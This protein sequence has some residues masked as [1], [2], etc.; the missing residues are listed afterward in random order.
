MRKLWL[1]PL[2]LALAL[3]LSPAY[4]QAPD[5]EAYTVQA[6]DWLSKLAE[7][8][9]GDPLAY[10]AIVDATNAKAAED[11]RFTAITNPDAIE[12]GQK[13]WI[14][15]ST[16]TTA[17]PGSGGGRLSVDQLKNASYDGIY[18]QPVTLVDGYYEGEP[19]VEG[20]A[21]RPTVTFVGDLVAYGDLNGDGVEDAAVLLAESSGGSGTFTYLAAVVNQDGQPVNA[22][23]VLLGDRTQIKSL[24]IQNGQIVMEIVTQGP[25]DP[26]CCPTLKVRKTYSL[27]DGQ[28]VEV[29]SE[30]L[31]QVSLQD[32]MG[33]S[34][35]VEQLDFD[36]PVQGDEPITAEF[37]DGQVAGSGGCN[38]YNAPVSS[39]DAQSLTIGPA[40]STLMACPEPLMTQEMQ[41]LT[42]LQNTMQWSYYI[43][44]LAL[45]YQQDDGSIGTLML[46]P[47]PSSQ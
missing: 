33:T 39:D 12:A 14:P 8:Y 16:G 45:T 26:M 29:G 40:I 46:L 44:K 25:D 9:Y 22:G 18:D 32:L 5:G 20:G 27:Q 38:R 1:L 19:F 11:D 15:T 23:T 34:W 31:G 2:V 6:G 21:S 41:Y 47:S 7:K 35:T 10:P 42:A 36:Q 24:A 4:A 43:G 3:S 28:L 13:I 30:E 17:P 37:A